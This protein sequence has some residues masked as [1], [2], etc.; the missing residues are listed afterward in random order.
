MIEKKSLKSRFFS[1]TSHFGLT[2]KTLRYV[3]TLCAMTGFS[4]FRLRSGFDGQ[5]D[6]WYSVQL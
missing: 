2:G 5:F 3:I 4:L 6:Y 1:R